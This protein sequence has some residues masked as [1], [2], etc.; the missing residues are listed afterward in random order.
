MTEYLVSYET[1]VANWTVT[2]GAVI[3]AESEEDAAAKAKERYDGPGFNILLVA[4]REAFMAR[5]KR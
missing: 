3:E 5:F 1:A 4:E 2:N